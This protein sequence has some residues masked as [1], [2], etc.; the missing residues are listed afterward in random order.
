MQDKAKAQHRADSHTHVILQL[1]HGMRSAA[2]IAYALMQSA[3]TGQG[4][5]TNNPRMQDTIEGRLEKR[6][7]GVFA[8]VG[9]KRLVAFID[10]LNMPQKSPFGFIPPLEL[11]KLWVD[12]GFWYDR[13]SCEPK[14]V[15]DMQ[16]LAAMAPPGGGRNAFSA[17]ILSCFSMLC[18]SSPSDSQLRRIFSSLL[19]T[20]LADFGDAIKPLG[21]SITQARPPP[22]ALFPCRAPS[23]DSQASLS[24]SIGQTCTAVPGCVWLSATA[25]E[26]TFPGAHAGDCGALQ[27]SRSGAAPNSDQV[28]LPIQ[29][30]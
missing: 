3:R 5:E 2:A 10:D 15:R 24:V 17:R 8:P 27:G 19:S 22:A 9:G 30:A 13:K 6:S 11:L 28:A 1:H 4:L 18:V 21:E 29:H 23:A 14:E 26:H 7:K 16:L 12:N 20:H 25:C